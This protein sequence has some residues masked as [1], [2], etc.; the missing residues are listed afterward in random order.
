MADRFIWA[1]GV[2]SGRKKNYLKAGR[3]NEY[4]VNDV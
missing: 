4:K 1:K 3:I 2:D